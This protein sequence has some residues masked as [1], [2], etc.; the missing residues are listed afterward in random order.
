M[1]KK[2][3]LVTLLA[4]SSLIASPVFAQTGTSTP[5][6]PLVK[7][8]DLSCVQTAVDAREDALDTAFTT[9]T[10]AE[11]AALSAR[12]SA[13]HDAWGIAAAKDRRAARNKAWSAFKTA[14]RA[15]FSALRTARAQAWSAFG[16][17]SAA[18]HSPVVESH[19]VEGVGSIGL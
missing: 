8:V 14:N 9:F 5:T 11:S 19:D 18:C 13:L 17:A 3:F 15:A 1:D 16:T 4:A 6:H 7:T 12:K 10:G 2:I